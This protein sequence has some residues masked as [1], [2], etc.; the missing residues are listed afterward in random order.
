M[1]DKGYVYVLM[2]PSMNNLVKIGKTERLPTERA[3]ELSSTTG[4]PTPFIVVYDCY[5]ESCSDAEKFVHTLLEGKGYRVSSH[6]EFF[7]IPVKDAIDAV[8]KAKE[9]FGEFKVN[10]DSLISDLDESLHT[11]E[12]HEEMFRIAE[13]YRHGLGDELMD[14]VEAT[15]YYLKAIEL[16]S[17]KSHCELG[18]MQKQLNEGDKAMHIF[19]EGAKGGSAQCYAE[20]AG[21]YDL[22]DQQINAEKC[23]KRYFQLS[24]FDTNIS[25]DLSRDAFYIV[26]YFAFIRRHDLKL[27]HLDK[28]AKNKNNIMLLVSFLAS[29][30]D[31]VANGYHKSFHTVDEH[32]EWFHKLLE[33]EDRSL[34]LG[35]IENI[36]SIQGLLKYLVGEFIPT[37]D[38][39]ISDPDENLRTIESHEEMFEIAE[40]YRNGRSDKLE[41]PQ[42]ALKYH[43]RAIEL[44]STESYLA[45]GE[46]YEDAEE[47]DKAMQFFREGTKRG[48]SDCCAKIA[49]SLLFDKNVSKTDKYWEKYFSLSSSENN[50]LSVLSGFNE[51]HY[52]SF[53][54]HHKDI[55][56]RH[57]RQLWESKDA[58]LSAASFFEGFAY[59]G[60]DIKKYIETIF[61]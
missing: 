30:E 11:I 43:L 28:I 18:R 58:I 12:P 9:H 35:S 41:D 56:L 5:F 6:R 22:I 38:D 10:N 33:R 49:T 8:M 4:V 27:Q 48:N 26:E 55:K 19:K 46:M 36:R 14:L 34:I 7:E 52:I 50:T 53:V 17:V 39:R 44:G 60:E 25:D 20:M 29:D 57:V 61:K 16:G 40:D 47:N 32:N 51:Y 45:V 21:L 37:N 42:K 23:W 3:K 24:T 1:S 31:F 54:F 59:Y 2:N 13:T 15:N